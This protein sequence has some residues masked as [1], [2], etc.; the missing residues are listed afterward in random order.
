MSLTPDLLF[1]LLPV[2][3]FSGWLVARQGYRRKNVDRSSSG[4]EPAYYKGLNFL[5]NEQ[6]DK[7]IDVFI[8]LLEVD[9][10][11]VETHLALGSLFRKRGEVDR[12]IRIH[13]NL[14]ARPS[15]DAE[16][17]ANAL[18]ELG[19]DYMV[20]GLYDR[21]ENLFSELLESGKMQK[22]AL[23][24]LREIYQQEKVWDKCLEVS[25]ELEKYTGDT[26]SSE[27][28]HYYC[29][30]AEEALRQGEKNSAIDLIKKARQSD[31][32]SVRAL[33][34]EARLIKEQGNFDKAIKL[35]QQI[36]QID[37]DYTSEILLEM[38]DCYR[39]SVSPKNL[40]EEL[41]KLFNTSG[42]AAVLEQLV[43]QMNSLEGGRTASDFL[44]NRLETDAELPVL[45]LLTQVQQKNTTLT[46]NE[47][48]AVLS[49]TI[50]DEL[51]RRPLYNC[52]R[53]GFEAKMLHW[54]CPGCRSWGT[55]KPCDNN[56]RSTPNG[57]VSN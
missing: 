27:T 26:F 50:D 55:I 14:I 39:Q 40:L 7:A 44:L 34:I 42:N 32:G 30:L 35:Y 3:A 38:V 31:P 54:Q 11:T 49:K 23:Q 19:Q 16:Q 28:A 21:A 18:L 29:E 46:V 53:C 9:S 45:K 2:A 6:P 13:Q 47:L 17:R 22:K 25:R 37:A 20:A 33:L 4:Y 15:L 24:L 48:L 10:E 8:N 57:V 43:I 51:S 12:A 52:R 1:L 56:S 41:Y 36:L 5:L